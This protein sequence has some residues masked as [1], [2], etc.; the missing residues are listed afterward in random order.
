[1]STKILMAPRSYIQ[2]P[3]ALGRIGNHLKQCGIKNPIVMASPSALKMGHGI[4]A[5]SLTASGISHK[6]IEFRRECTF[7]EIDRIKK[8]CLDGGHD[9]I[10]SC[11][12]GKA[13][14]A[15]RA[16]GYMDAYRD[17]NVEDVW[18]DRMMIHKLISFAGVENL[19]H[20]RSALWN[21]AFV[22][23]LTTYPQ[24]ESN[25]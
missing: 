11:G 5:D 22:Q 17:W 24:G 9:A 1:M 13:M 12:G 4:I 7:A 20:N 15:G 23:A 14:D 19:A 10:I 21:A 18:S 25:E 16:N 6:F 2:G 8:A 3:G